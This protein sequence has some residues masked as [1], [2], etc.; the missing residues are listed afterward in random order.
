MINFNLEALGFSIW[1]D[2]SDCSVTCGTGT[3]TRTKTCLKGDCASVDLNQSFIHE[4]E[5]CIEEDCE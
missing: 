5:S 4:S 2:W 3:R 1:S